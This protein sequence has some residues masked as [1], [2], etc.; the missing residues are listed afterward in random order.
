MPFDVAAFERDVTRLNP[1]ARVIEISLMRGQ[2]IEQWLAWLACRI[3][4][5]RQ[6]KSSGFI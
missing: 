4:A 5:R 1:D 6:P 2:G 3:N